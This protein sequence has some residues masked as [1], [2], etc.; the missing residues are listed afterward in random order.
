VI[1]SDRLCSTLDLRFER[2]PGHLKQD[3]TDDWQLP[4]DH[5]LAEILILRNQDQSTLVGRCQDVGVSGASARLRNRVNRE[6]V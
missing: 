2:Q 6:T 4:Q 5:K 3:H 1:G